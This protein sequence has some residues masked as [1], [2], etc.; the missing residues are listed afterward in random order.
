MG[1]LWIKEFTGGLDARRMRETTSGGVL[2]TAKDGHINSGGEFE[3]RLA[4][5]PLFDAGGVSGTIGLA[6]TRTGLTVFGSDETPALPVGI[7]YQRLQHPTAPETLSLVDVP[8]W[9]LYAG[10]IYAVGVFSDGSI[11]HFYDGVNVDD[12]FDGRARAVF[13]VTA[14]TGSSQLTQI[15]VGGVAIMGSAVTWSTDN[16]T[17]AG[18]VAA[19]IAS[20][21]SSPEYTAIAVNDAVVILAD[22]AGTDGNGKVVSFTLATGFGVTPETDLAMSGGADLGEGTYQ[23]G[24]F[25]RTIDAKMNSLSSSNWH[26]SGIAAPDKWTTDATGAG[27][28]DVSTYASGAELLTTIAQYQNFAAVFSQSNISVWFIDPDPALYRKTQLL[29]NTGTVSP[30]SVTEFGDADLF[31]LD[32][33]GVRSLRA[34]DSSNA[35]SASDLGVPVDPLVRA[36]VAGLT[37]TERVRISGLIE[38]SNGRFW[39]CVKNKI[40]VYSFFQGVNVRAWSTYEQDFDIERTVVHDRKVYVRDTAGTIHVY[41]GLSSTAEYDDTQAVARTPFL[42]AEEPTVKKTLTGFDMAC[43]GVWDVWAHFDPT[44]PDAKDR[45]A[46]VSETTFGQAIPAQGEWTHISI[47]FESVGDGAAKVSSFIAK[48]ETIK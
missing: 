37:D 27:F 28:I 7:S 20:A 40:F 29:R 23:P 9:D 36:A 5:V 42:D 46:R 1:T 2:V 34:R 26:F 10:L 30:L 38:L 48:Y 33:S 31:Y 41:G 21:S 39:L 4:F 12:W 24:T 47:T 3:K 14:G 19:E 32:E 18:L 22:E 13:R 11:H 15:F 16:E 35:A 8:S 6:A 44:N 25:V 45:I 43:E 17:T